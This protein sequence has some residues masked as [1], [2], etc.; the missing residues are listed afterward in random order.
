MSSFYGHAESIYLPTYLIT[1]IPTY[2]VN[3]CVLN[4]KIG[5]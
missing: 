4:K 2:L 1:Y 5:C 3:K